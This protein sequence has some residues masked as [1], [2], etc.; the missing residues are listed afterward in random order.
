M[1]LNEMPSERQALRQVQ[2]L[3]SHRKVR[4]KSADSYGPLGRLQLRSGNIRP[5]LLEELYRP[6]HA[7]VLEKINHSQIHPLA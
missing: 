6:V 7:A 5:D 3:P 4:R 1:R 2:G